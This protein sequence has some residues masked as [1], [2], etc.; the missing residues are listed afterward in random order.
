VPEAWL[1]FPAKPLP[2]SV[3]R[4]LPSPEGVLNTASRVNGA[5]RIDHQLPMRF[6]PWRVAV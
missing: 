6:G 4:I 1:A 2:K 3:R 5:R